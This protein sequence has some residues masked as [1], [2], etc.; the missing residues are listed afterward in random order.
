MSTGSP[1]LEEC[2]A[3]A[4]AAGYEAILPENLAARAQAADD[5]LVEPGERLRDP[6]GWA[7]GD[8]GRW[9]FVGDV[10]V[11]GRN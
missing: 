7:H 11:K 1:I 4:V 10:S 3:R 9:V 5:P 6:Y 2:N 8:Q